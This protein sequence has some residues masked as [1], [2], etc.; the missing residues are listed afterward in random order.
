MDA[1]LKKILKDIQKEYDMDD[2]VID[3]IIK[4]LKLLC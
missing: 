4:K 3:P 2:E 1:P